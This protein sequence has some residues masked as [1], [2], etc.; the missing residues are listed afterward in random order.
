LTGRHDEAGMQIEAVPSRR[1]RPRS[2]KIL[3]YRGLFRFDGNRR[4]SL[5]CWMKSAAADDLERGT[6]RRVHGCWSRSMES[7]WPRRSRTRKS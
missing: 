1:Q 7:W 3:L 5:A 2:N 4:R 6:K